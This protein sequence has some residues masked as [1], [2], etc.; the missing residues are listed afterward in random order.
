MNFINKYI[1]DSKSILDQLD[2]DQISNMI[3]ILKETR[4]SDGRLFILVVGGGAGHAPRSREAAAAATGFKKERE[5]WT[6]KWGHPSIRVVHS[7]RT[8]PIRLA[9]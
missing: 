4:E 5:G 7:V 6:E 9:R 8:D 3:S 1:S 2:L